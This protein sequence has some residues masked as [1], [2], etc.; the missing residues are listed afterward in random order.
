M[1]DRKPIEDATVWTRGSY[2][3]PSMYTYELDQDQTAEIAVAAKALQSRN[4]PAHELRRDD[5]PLPRTGPLLDRLHSDLEDGRGFALLR[6]WPAADYS[7]AVNL[8]AFCGITAHLGDIVIQNYEGQSSVDVRNE[9]VPYTHE[10][11]GYRSNKLLPFHTDGADLAALLCLGVAARGGLSIIASATQVFNTIL[12]E[13]PEALTLLERGFFHHRRRQHPEG[14]DPVSAQRIP[15]FAFRKGVLHCCY[16]RNPIDWVEKEGVNLSR[17]EKSVLDYFDSVV[18]RPELHVSMQLQIGDMQF[19]NN[20]VILHS[21]TEFTDDET[22]KRH[23]VRLWAED[24][25]SRRI[26]ESLLDL[27]VPGSSRYAAAPQDGI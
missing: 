17:A 5:F 20:F 10:S 24:P 18:E 21:R 2:N 15:V 11:R 7:Y 25:G 1:P 13:R 12:I 8:A 19:L 22:H 23:L 16:N 4:I 14:E 3:D 6:G 26:G 9:N 27:Y